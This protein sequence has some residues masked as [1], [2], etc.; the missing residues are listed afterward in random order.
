M[1]EPDAGRP[2]GC[3]DA[4]DEC[5]I[6]CEF[7][8]SGAPLSHYV[9]SMGE[10]IVSITTSLTRRLLAG[11]V[12]GAV[13]LGVP[14]AAGAAE[15]PATSC[16]NAK[17]ALA[18][19]KTQKANAHRDAALAKVA[20]KKAAHSHADARLARAEARLD[21]AQ[22]R[23]AAMTAKAHDAN[24]QMRHNCTTPAPVT[25]VSPTA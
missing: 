20:V 3:V 9:Q 24:L 4:W 5:P 25:P 16:Q 17:A 15:P 21:A 12:L 1:G 23:L 13:T 10:H 11:A 14:A 8:V 2:P 18:H 7:V 6:C 22:A 19:A